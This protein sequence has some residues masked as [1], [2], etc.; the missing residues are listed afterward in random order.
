M[1]RL[2]G[3]PADE[4]ASYIDLRAA[5]DAGRRPDPALRAA[6][7]DRAREPD[8]SGRYNPF[9]LASYCE[10]AYSDSPPD[11][12]QLRDAPGDP[13]VELR[14]IGRIMDDAVRQA[15]PVAVE[16][17]RFDVELIRPALARVG[18]DA[19]KAFAGLAAQEW[20]RALT[21][22][23][24]GLPGVIEVDE[25][26]RDRIRAALVKSGADTVG[27]PVQLGRDAAALIH[28]GPVRDVPTEV[29][30]AAVRLL[31]AGEAAAMWAKLEDKIVTESAWPW[32]ET[33]TVRAGAVEMQRVGPQT[34]LAAIL[35]TQAAARIHAGITEGL[36]DLWQQVA[37]TAG[38]Y[39]VLGGAFRFEAR[40]VLGL[41]AIGEDLPVHADK[42]S[43]QVLSAAARGAELGSLVAALD[44]PIGRGDR[45]PDVLV[46]AAAEAVES[47]AYGVSRAGLMLSLAT[48]ALKDGSLRDAA[49]LADEAL[50]TAQTNEN[51]STGPG[52]DCADWR[53]PPGLVDR[54]RLTCLL[55][56]C[57]Q[58]GPPDERMQTWRDNAL[59]RPHDA[60]AQRLAAFTVQYELGYH[61][62]AAEVLSSLETD[63]PPGPAAHLGAPPGTPARRAA[64]GGVAC[65]RR[66]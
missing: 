65:A 38:R 44:G 52:R 45:P 14:I 15:L 22:T 32:A 43:A 49:L 18:V 8:G 11:A 26:L 6:I 56:S 37:D 29:V 63:A 36:A 5:Q 61:P 35:A 1:L 58:G 51:T 66:P 64:R 27:D 48:L 55:I 62:V 10:W 16:F 50:A 41:A 31:P 2:Q 9:E 4:A 24:D 19:D 17:G 40:A 30:E 34:I 23:A 60:D 42:A 7:L 39:P 25:H 20:T 21:V 33:V 28:S 59:D 12:A 57:Q 13:Y 3:L 53:P 54:C 46:H 47:A